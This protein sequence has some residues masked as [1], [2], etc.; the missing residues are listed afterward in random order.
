MTAGLVVAIGLLMLG[1][2]PPGDSAPLEERVRSLE[3]MNR[4]LIEQIEARD[5][6][7]DE[8]Y[9]RLE[10]KYD[11]LRRDLPAKPEEPARSEPNPKTEPD[12]SRVGTPEH[13][14][15]NTE[16]RGRRGRDRVPLVAELG[17]GFEFETEDQEYQLRIHILDQTDAK[18]FVP[19]DQNPA[20]SGLYIPRV[21]LYFEGQLTRLFDYE[22]SIQRSVEGVWDL[23][24]ANVNT[25]ASDAVQLKFGR[26]LV[27][28]SYDWYDHLEQYFLTPERALFP[29]NFGIARSAGLMI[30]GRPFEGR[31]QYAV[32]GFDGHL[33]GLADDNNTRDAVG[34][35]NL[36]PFLHSEREL[37]RGFNFG[38]SGFLGQQVKAVHPLPLRS[39]LQSSENDE[40]AQGASSVFLV[41]DDRAYALGGRSGGAVHAAWYGRGFSFESEIQTGRNHYALAGVPGQVS[42]PLSGGHA[43][44]SYFLTGEVVDGRGPFEPL[45][46]FRPAKGQWGPG[47]FEVVGRYSTLKLGDSVF[48]SGLADRGDWTRQA[49][50]TDLGLNWYLT[51]YLKVYAFWQHIA[52]D[53][54]VLIN[55]N[56][57]R[58][59]NTNDLFW[60]RLQLYF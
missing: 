39:A 48:S 55:P 25:H 50:M 18:F 11:T 41:F 35:V 28:Y 22:V 3:E 53:T 4:K 26:M 36:R 51:K 49:G 30:H 2:A 7:A 14:T 31:M 6:A 54:P 38:A 52:Y 37:L 17:E 24:D 29:L 1:D 20:R 13:L 12:S 34:Y 10:A 32:G 45:H 43:G 47:A 60:F 40:A 58:F 9:K 44:L 8:R 33:T 19:G 5:R 27:P 59:S 46:P 15:G 56:K 57:G 21:R 42:V 23:L 16:P